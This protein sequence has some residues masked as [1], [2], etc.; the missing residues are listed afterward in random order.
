MDL[1]KDSELE[2]TLFGPGYGEALCIHIGNGY[3]VLIDSCRD[4]D[5][6]SASLQYLT[7][8]G[9]DKDKVLFII[10]SHWHD[11]HIK[12]VTNLVRHFEKATVIFSPL[13]SE[14]YF[15]ALTEQ[16][17]NIGT[18][19]GGGLREIRNCLDIALNENRIKTYSENQCIFNSATSGI[20]VGQNLKI[21]SVSPSNA[22]VTEESI[23]FTKSFEI[24]SKDY[25][26]SKKENHASIA[27]H[28][29][30]PEFSVLLGSDLETYHSDKFGWG[31][32]LKNNNVIESKCDLFKIPH[33]GS[34][35]AYHPDVWKTLISDEPISIL[36]PFKNGNVDLPK[37]AGVDQLKK[38]SHSVYITASNS[39]TK[40]HSIKNRAAAKILN[41]KTKIKTDAT[42]GYSTG[43]ITVRKNQ[44]SPPVVK[45]LGTAI[46]LQ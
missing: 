6:K 4:K 14:K 3:W 21:H 28:I 8:I 7:S 43:Q 22:G 25:V 23:G 12:G 30:T 44:G 40:P 36:T 37:A 20:D 45:R 13:I 18:K 5:G 41:R 39:S 9:I 2:I 42:T 17:K 16:L 19:N 38:D 27:I 15:L 46:Q 33:H 32:V 10:I 24:G 11:D 34:E 1:P 31:A 35:G 26:P 29:C